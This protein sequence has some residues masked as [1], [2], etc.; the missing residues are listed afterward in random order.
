MIKELAKG[1]AEPLVLRILSDGPLHG[2]AI[3]HQIKERS[4]EVLEFTEGT[5]YPL[6]HSLEQDGLVSAVW[7]ALPSGRRRKVYCI[8]PAGHRR[9][10]EAKDEWSKFRLVIDS[11]FGFGEGVRGGV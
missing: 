1:T 5:I 2:Y 4:H 3:L 7:E 11:I 10:T 6:L 9:L 8:T